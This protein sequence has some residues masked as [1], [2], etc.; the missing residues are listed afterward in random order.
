MTDGRSA[1]FTRWTAEAGD[2]VDLAIGA[3]RAAVFAWYD[4]DP[5]APP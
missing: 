1:V 5:D 4:L 3:T 2:G